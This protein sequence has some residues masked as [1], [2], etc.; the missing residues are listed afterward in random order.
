V[1]AFS[2]YLHVNRAPEIV[3]PRLTTFDHVALALRLL[4]ADNDATR[5]DR[6]HTRVRPKLARF[7]LPADASHRIAQRA[8]QRN[9]QA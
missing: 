7:N 6:A 5:S 9:A 4:F 1:S 2:C 3:R 8:S